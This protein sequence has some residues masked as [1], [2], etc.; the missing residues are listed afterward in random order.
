MSLRNSFRPLACAALCAAAA[1]PLAAETSVL[2][3]GGDLYSLEIGRAEALLESPA[4]DPQATVLV[5]DLTHD[6]ETERRVV[7]GSEDEDFE[8]SASMVY[9]PFS[10]SIYVIW[11]SQYQFAHSRIR[12]IQYRDGAWSEPIDITNDPFTF[13]TAPMVA[14]TR[15]S[16]TRAEDDVEHERTIL[17]TLWFEEVW[18]GDAVLYSPLVLVDG[19]FIDRQATVTLADFAESDAL[20][21]PQRALQV[22]P[23]ITGGDSDHKVVATV[24]DSASN[25]L[26][27]FEIEALALEVTDLAAGVAESV[28]GEGSCASGGLVALS[29]EARANIVTIARDRGFRAS[30]A[31]S[32]ANES[33]SVLRSREDLCSAPS[34]TIEWEVAETIIDAGAELAGGLFFVESDARANIVTIARRGTFDHRLV[35]R[36]MTSRAAPKVGGKTK[37]FVSRD[38]GANIVAWETEAGTVRYVESDGSDDGW[39]QPRSLLTAGGLL[40][41]EATRLLTG[42]LDG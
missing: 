40:S 33:H 32:L 30:I 19:E 38:G 31:R 20:G 36:G 22:S 3:S 5:L 24:L 21:A 18:G 41:A 16:F 23:A 25:R 12:L 42:R 14:V 11:A 39:S 28:D 1:L 4:G 10:D 27:T 13:K 17:H 7:P 29:Q 26:L 35:I 15:E 37:V 2:G 9:E 6:G 8:V 34:E